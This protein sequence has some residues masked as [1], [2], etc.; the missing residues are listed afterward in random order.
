MKNIALAGAF[1][2]LSIA[3]A[4]AQPS[5]TDQLPAVSTAANNVAAVETCQTQLRRLDELSKVLA[6]N[7][8][9]EHV[10]EVCLDRQ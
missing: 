1:A 10:R 2:L 4:G 3:P 9:A 7:Y 8:N 5:A 6:V